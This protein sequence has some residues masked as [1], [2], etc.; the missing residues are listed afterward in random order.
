MALKIIFKK[1]LIV[2]FIKML[3]SASANRL[4]R[5]TRTNKI[6]KNV[7]KRRANLHKMVYY[8]LYLLR[9]YAGKN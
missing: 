1:L 9:I 4:T 6:I 3:S 5:L 7:F 8:T 2:K